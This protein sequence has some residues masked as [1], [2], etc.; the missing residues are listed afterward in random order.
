MTRRRPPATMEGMS[1][2][3]PVSL[4]GLPEAPGAK[5]R[6]LSKPVRG[7]AQRPT[8]RWVGWL[9]IALPSLAVVG[10]L[11]AVGPVSAFRVAVAVLL[12][13]AAWDWWR[14]RDRS[15]TFWGCLGLAVAFPFAGGIALLAGNAPTRAALVELAD[16]V[17]MFALAV[18]LVQLYRTS[19]T[20]LTICRGWLY[21]IV[22]L[23]L[24]SLVRLTAGSPPAGAGLA[25]PGQLATAAATAL[26]GMP[27]GFALESDRRLRWAYPAAATLVLLPLAVLP[28]A[29]AVVAVIAVSVAWAIQFR[30]GR[31]AAAVAV[32]GSVLL[33]LGTSLAARVAAASVDLAHGQ[34]W[35]LALDGAAYLRR[36][37][38]LGIGPA[39]FEHMML[40]T[41]TPY[42]TGSI[43]QP[44]AAVVEIVSQYGLGIGVAVSLAVLGL[45]RW[46]VQR[47]SR[48]R[49]TALHSPQRAPA[50]W[51][52]AI[53]AL[54]PVISAGTG[55][56]LNQPV[57][58][59]AVASIALIARL[60]ERPKGRRM[61]A[62][63]APLK[64]IPQEP[65]DAVLPPTAK[66]SLPVGSPA[67][68]S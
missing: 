16:V 3:R 4:Q 62:P 42:P 40:T 48:A 64:S 21:S 47:L 52:L 12:G 46:S 10:P 18:S 14:F 54:A 11:A 2:P 31:V 65:G 67:T 28:S 63:T 53:L 36:S 15:R 49:G 59:M 20:V 66:S 5:S 19:E 58:A 23:A 7:V 60:V 8:P 38:F 29:P 30:W 1:K 32:L 55:T 44:H 51:L 39:G 35:S 43:T 17:V 6:P 45:A 22:V 24:I 33:P 57:S 68:P 37:H 25:A 34:R 13:T 9:L 27:L 26:I 61:V 41:V 56:W 50:V